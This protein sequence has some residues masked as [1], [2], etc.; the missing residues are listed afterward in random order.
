MELRAAW[1]IMTEQEKQAKPPRYYMSEAQVID[2]KT[3]KCSDKTVT[4][5][6]IGFH[7]A[8]KTGVFKA[9]VWSTFEQVDNVPA[10]GVPPPALGYSL[11]DGKNQQPF[12]KS[13]GFFSGAAYKPVDPQSL[14]PAPTT[15]VQVIRL[16][17][18]KS[19]IK[20]LND[21]VHQVAG[22]KGTVWENYELVD[23]Q[24]QN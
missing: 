24:W 23:A 2:P 3:G 20:A 8:H 19:E 21:Q 16:D 17:P 9:W 15:P 6:L 4:V 14:K 5:G 1:R 11:Y 10:D 22:I 13:W 12:L 7:I 18:I